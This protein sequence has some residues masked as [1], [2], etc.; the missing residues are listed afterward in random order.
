MQRFL[1]AVAFGEKVGCKVKYRDVSVKM[2]LG[3]AKVQGVSAFEIG[4]L[5]STAMPS[6]KRTAS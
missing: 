6:L 5:E 3:A 4:H 1:P 2:P